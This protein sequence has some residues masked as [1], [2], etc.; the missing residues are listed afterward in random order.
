MKTKLLTKQ[1]KVWIAMLMAVCA[2]GTANAAAVLQMTE[3][4]WDPA[5][6]V[7][8]TN[9]RLKVKVSNIGDAA[10][11][12]TG[13]HGIIFD[14]DAQWNG[15]GWFHD[16][17]GNE[18]ITINAGE[19][20]WYIVDGNWGKTS[21]DW[22]LTLGVHTINVRGD[23][24]ACVGESL[25][26]RRGFRV[27]IPASACSTTPYGNNGNP[28]QAS[29]IAGQ[30]VTIRARDFDDG[31]SGCSALSNET[32][33]NNNRFGVN[34]DGDNINYTRSGDFLI[35][36][37][38]IPVDGTYSI[39]TNASGANGD[40][41]FS[42]DILDNN[43]LV[44]ASTNFT[45]P[46]RTNNWQ[47]F[48]DETTNAV[49]LSAG[50]YKFK[51]KILNIG[52]DGDANIKQ[53]KINTVTAAVCTPPA[54]PTFTAGATSIC[55]NTSGL[56]YTVG[57]VANATYN[58]TVPTGWTITGGAGTNSITVTAG[59]AG[60][61]VKVNVTVEDCP[62]EDAVRTV[63]V[64]TQ[65]AAPVLIQGFA[66]ICRGDLNASL[67]DIIGNPYTDLFWQT[68]AGGTD[69]SNP[70]G[71]GNYVVDV[72]DLNTAGV[73]VYI[74][75]K[76][77]AGCW[78]EAT[79]V[80]VVSSQGS[81]LECENK[82]KI[83]GIPNSYTGPS[84]VAYGAG[85]FIGSNGGGSAAVDTR[86]NG[87]LNS[88]S[89]AV[90]S[91]ELVANTNMEKRIAGFDVSGAYVEWT[92]VDGGTGTTT[93]TLQYI[94]SNRDSGGKVSI[95]VNGTVIG[96]SN[97]SGNGGTATY[98]KEFTNVTLTSGTTNTVRFT[99]ISK[100][101]PV[102]FRL[103]YQECTGTGEGGLCPPAVLNCEAPTSVSVS[104]GGQNV[105]VGGTVTALSAVPVGGA[106]EG[107]LTYYYQWYSNTENNNT[108]GAAIG[109]A[110]GSTYAPSS[111]TA[112]TTYY[113]VRVFTGEGINAC[114]IT[115]ATAAVSVKDKPAQPGAFT[116]SAALVLQGTAQ[117]YT[118]PN[119]EGVT[120]NW[121]VPTGWTITA[122]QG[123]N[124]ISVTPG[125]TAVN[126]TISVAASN[127][128]GSSDPRSISVSVASITTT[129]V[130]GPFFI[131]NGYKGF[132]YQYLQANGTALRTVRYANE[133]AGLQATNDLWII[134]TLSINGGAS[135]GYLI[136]NVNTGKYINQDVNCGPNVGNLKDLPIATLINATAAD[137]TSDANKTLSEFIFEFPLP[138][139][140][141]DIQFDIENVN[142]AAVEGYTSTIQSKR[143]TQNAMLRAENS[144]N[145]QYFT[146]NWTCQ[147][148]K[149]PFGDQ[150]TRLWEFLVDCP[151]VPIA[152]FSL[153]ADNTTLCS[154]ETA[155]F[156]LTGASQAEVSYTLY[157]GTTSVD[158]QTGN[159]GNI[160]FAA[161]SQAGTYTVKAQGDGES[162]CAAE[163]AAIGGSVMLTVKNLALG[164][165]A[166]AEYN[167]GTTNATALN[168]AATGSEGYTYKWYSNTMN[169]SSGGV[170]IS[171]ETSSTYQPEI[172]E[173]ISEC[174]QYLYY[175]VVVTD[176]CGQS[177]TS[178]VAI[179][180]V[181][182]PDCVEPDPDGGCTEATPYD[183]TMNGLTFVG[184]PYYIRNSY[185]EG[186]VGNNY[187]YLWDNEAEVTTKERNEY[188]MGTDGS[189]Y[190]NYGWLQRSSNTTESAAYV[191][192][193][194]KY[195]WVIYKKNINSTDYY[196]IKNLATGRF[197]HTGA[198]NGENQGTVEF[199]RDNLYHNAMGLKAWDNNLANVTNI[200]NTSNDTK[201]LSYYMNTITNV[202][203]T[204]ANFT[205]KILINR[206][207]WGGKY[208][209]GHY[210]DAAGSH[211][212]GRAYYSEKDDWGTTNWNFI[213]AN[214][215]MT[216]TAPDLSITNVAYEASS[217]SFTLT[218]VSIEN[219]G[220]AAAIATA[221]DPIKLK[222]Q[223][224]G[225]WATAE[226]TSGSIAAGATETFD[227]T[228][229]KT[230]AVSE[231]DHTLSIIVY[232]LADSNCS[233]NT[234]YF[235]VTISDDDC[236]VGAQT[237]CS[238]LEFTTVALP[239]SYTWTV[240]VT[241][242]A[243][244][245]YPTTGTGTIEGSVLSGEGVV[246]FT[247]TPIS[248]GQNP[249]DGCVGKPVT[250]TVTV[251]DAEI[252][253]PEVTIAP[254]GI[255]CEDVTTTTANVKGLVTTNCLEAAVELVYWKTGS[256]TLTTVKLPAVSGFDVTVGTKLVGLSPNTT[257]SFR[258]KATNAEGAAESLEGTFTTAPVPPVITSEPVMMP[259]ID[260]ESF[261]ITWETLADCIYT[262]EWSRDPEFKTNVYSLGE[263]VSP[264]TIETDKAGTYFYRVRMT[265]ATSCPSDWSEVISVV[266]TTGQTEPDPGDSNTCD[267]LN[268]DIVA[269]E[270]FAI[271][272]NTIGTG[273]D[274][275]EDIKFLAGPFYIDNLWNDYFNQKGIY[276]YDDGNESESDLLETNNGDN[277]L[278]SNYGKL[279]Q[280][281]LG[282]T[283]NYRNDAEYMWIIYQ[284]KNT[285]YYLIRNVAISFSPSNSR[286]GISTTAKAAVIVN[287][288]IHITY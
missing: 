279:K 149:D 167:A 33:Q 53:I 92:G 179:I 3:V 103:T 214:I 87:G 232:G 267:P 249:L 125:S 69:L 157:R 170:V 74:R 110:T 97:T 114:A 13:K 38:N 242:G 190:A 172:P 280:K 236:T 135:Y 191:D 180:T 55:P 59:A 30:S 216:T 222:F 50:T 178:N 161:Q 121:T 142:T 140:V 118:V 5:N 79:A 235:G 283:T 47:T 229:V 24:G 159:G 98:N 192:G 143:Y 189:I 105:C 168:P 80:K 15:S 181:N 218:G 49:A 226:I 124:S 240:E 108:T 76:N 238:G 4:A 127:E 28:W 66:D 253:V 137:A 258:I 212:A 150:S 210:G 160:T 22:Q 198:S 225:K 241:E 204:G 133:Q 36:T 155:T 73:T 201:E 18:T 120:Y 128:C 77:A 119:V 25:L 209:H 194:E 1:W 136:K 102:G 203:T 12:C 175:Y 96:E 220:E 269:P 164:S 99:Y 239:E 20:H 251:I 75:S 82:Y 277:T 107:E 93:A 148:D 263:V 48:R 255:A 250:F 57:T 254:E 282:K 274:L 60:G 176:N 85:N 42:Y 230:I 187:Q 169:S 213:A 68:T 237:I 63:S 84:T 257:Y 39:S 207:V 278:Y 32:N 152:G 287:S 40:Y 171:G 182:N 61:D 272:D 173:A 151:Q 101:S 265:N 129:Q 62:S 91:S 244:T 43:M 156:T 162:Y 266:Q 19:S 188:D 29:A 71:S 34:L 233:D 116:A 104:N 217:N 228:G 271:A 56:V 288:R 183:F 281:D 54:T 247:I 17:G 260:A 6:A 122:G 166:S 8:G 88:M 81:S 193:D 14:V 197:L 83:Y 131:R 16:G 51:L 2:F 89:P 219:K 195:M 44:V 276:L 106:S 95:S 200:N 130:A 227:L 72:N 144:G 90:N 154:G 252:G 112:G 208:L 245:G 139:H 185:F 65:P 223:L 234:G 184:G 259:E 165:L 270:S 286:H 206:W 224:D 261:I 205:S 23:N 115:S 37:V 221:Q 275:S 138:E 215:N 248:T 243:V 123:T 134:E 58:W 10:Y 268:P 86:T 262:M 11:T 21:T 199:S 111:A 196:A 52:T 141:S 158:V 147:L 46:Y 285:D 94:D 31:G 64:N 273:C 202:S 113:Y 35:Y 153:S 231:G 211:A 100:T 78:S 126:G 45:T 264:A 117:T 284:Y 174:T 132:G 41:S 177:T 26:P 256:A 146:P 67:P 27:D 163:T 145:A 9:V 246:V 109:N 186:D 7:A 70:L